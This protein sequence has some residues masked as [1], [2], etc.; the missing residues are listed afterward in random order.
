MS[1]S[2]CASAL[3]PWNVTSRRTPFAFTR[4]AFAVVTE[5]TGDGASN[6]GPVAAAIMA[7]V[8]KK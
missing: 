8:L 6:A 7:Q 2:F 1:L 3:P 4:Y 5:G